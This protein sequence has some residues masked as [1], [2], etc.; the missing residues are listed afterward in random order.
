MSTNFPTALDTLTNPTLTDYLNSPSHA[1]QHANANDS[2]EAL[3]AKVGINSSA[4][5]TSHDYKIAALET[6]WVSVSD[7]WSYASA[8]APTFTITVPSGAASLYSPGMRI[9]LTQ[10]TVK[11]FI[12]TAVADTVLTVYGGTDYILTSDAISEISYSTQKAPFG[13]PL[14]PAKWSVETLITSTINQNSPTAGTWYNLATVNIIVPIG[15]WKLYYAVEG[16][17]NRNTT[18]AID[19]E[20]A[21][22]TSNNSV[23]DYRL[24]SRGLSSIQVA[25]NCYV[26]SLLSKCIDITVP[27]KTTYY[28]IWRTST[29]ASAISTDGDTTG[30]QGIIRAV[31]AY[32]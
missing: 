18:G 13:F 25:T 2:I 5:T 28:A 31:C 8:D 22:S 23:S 17:A 27:S 19:I 7:S 6:G 26:L 16:N 32:L 29:G 1:G 9:R 10:T 4:V 11:Y 12:I 21:L 24:K 15:E 30:Q 14:S 3:E 20:F